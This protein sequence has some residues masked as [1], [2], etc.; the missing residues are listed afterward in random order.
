MLFVTKIQHF[1]T[2]DG[3]GIRTT[4]FFKGCPLHCEWC[5]NPET[6]WT[7]S[8]FFYSD[9]LCIRCGG[10]VAVCP[11]KVHTL[12]EAGHILNRTACNGCKKC[13]SACSTGALEG[14]AEVLSV[15]E[16]F[17]NV[18][19]DAVFYGDIGGV[20]FSGGEPTVY[21]EELIELLKL[22]H[23]NG[24]NTAIETCGYFDPTILPEL[25]KL[26]DL[27]LWDVKDTDN[28]RHLMNTGV[29]NKL[30]TDNL[31]AADAL[32]AKTV[33]RCILLSGVNLFTEHLLNI[34]S[35]YSSLKNC[36]GVELIPYHTYGASKRIQLGLNENVHREWIPSA[37]ELRKAKELLRQYNVPVLDN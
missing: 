24:I 1:C 35:L 15:D 18:M 31:M 36:S 16:I 3:P 6:Q 17:C 37:E 2:K 26:T 19:K 11:L 20:T 21:A 25:V 28:E 13:V 14:C 5:H 23:D 34:A 22:F 8:P 32:G 29:S 33:L 9:R 30:I 27:F 12:T 10:C 4:V 7:A